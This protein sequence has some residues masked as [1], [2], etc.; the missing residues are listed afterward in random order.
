MIK[1]FPEGSLRKLTA[2]L[3]SC[4]AIGILAISNILAQGRQTPF[5]VDGVV[6]NTQG[7]P[8]MDAVVQI[9]ESTSFTVTDEFGNFSIEIPGTNT[10]IT[11]VADGF[12]MQSVSVYDNTFLEIILRFA[13]EGQR[14]QDRVFVPWGVSDKRS[15]TSSISTIGHSELRKSPVLNL[16]G[17]VSG[18]LPGFTVVQQ[19]GAPGWESAT[20]RVRG[21]RTLEDGGWNSMSKGAVGTPIV[22]VD[23]FERGFTDL[24]PSEIESFSVLKDAAATVLYG[25]RGANGVILVNTRR[26]QANRR[27]IDLEISSGI[28]SPLRLPE[29]LGSYD[30][31][32]LH[33]EARISDGLLPLYSDDDLEKYR[34]GSDPLTHPNN[35][36]YDE[37]IKPYTFQRKS[38]LSMS[39][40]N[41]IVRY[42]VSVVYNNLGSLYDRMNE[43]PEFDTQSRS[44]MYNVRANLDISV[45]RRLS[46]A[47]NLAG[48]I[49][50][51]RYPYGS[52]TE[53]SIFGLL[54]DTPPNAY[55]ISFMGIEPSLNQEILMLGGNVIY[56]TN[57]LGQLS[58]RG[59]S[60]RIYRFFQLGLQF[61][62]DLDFITE[63]L[64][65]SFTFDAD[66]FNYYR[67]SRYKN[68]QVWER[69]VMPD[70]SINY[71]YFNEP[72]SLTTAIGT[73]VEYY[74]GQNLNLTYNRSF[75]LSSIGGLAMWRRY[76]TIIK[77][78]NQPDK[79]I[80]DFAL[81]LNYSF[82]NRYFIE[83][84]A[85]L[86]GSDNFFETNTPRVF[87]P[88]I[89]GAWI[90]SEESFFNNSAAFP[91]V[92]LKA[93]WGLTGNEDYT[94]TDPNGLKYRFPY[95]E[96]WWSSNSR[97][98][99]GTSLAYFN[100]I[101]YEGIL[102]NPDF[103]LEKGRMINFGI[104]TRHLDNRLSF[105][106]EVWFEK[107][108]DIFTRGVGSVPQVIGIRETYLP[109]ENKGIVF[110]K[111]IETLLGWRSSG[112][113]FN[114][115]VNGMVD[116]FTNRI[117]F[118]D[119]PFKEYDYLYETGGM[120]RQ[121]IALIAAGLF[122]DQAD[123]D[124]SPVQMFGP[125]KPGDIKFKDLNGDNIIDAL[126][127][128]TVG[129][130]TFPQLSYAA[131]MGF[132]YLGF[133]FSV[134]F[135]GSS[136][137]SVINRNSVNQA[138]RNNS[139]IASYA[140]GRYTDAA[141]WENATYPRLTTIAND[142]NYRGST[143]WMY[144]LSFVRVKNI[145]LGYNLPDEAV[146]KLGLY[147]VRFF[148]NGYNLMT[149]SRVKDF[150]PEDLTA[151]I[152]KYPMTSIVNL[153][154]NL[155]F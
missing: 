68:Y 101:V 99:Y 2:R 38:A 81:R 76:T 120:V 140:L 27:T 91:Y 92:K 70:N 154:I 7:I 150:D 138:F 129:Y 119:E 139:N 90:I 112:S 10:I 84:S 74:N 102:P 111:G 89:S 64:A 100:P 130:S 24:D 105:T 148:L 32:R 95:R 113:K 53:S 97:T 145:E 39:G 137:R 6:L 85:V 128:K 126:D 14:I 61:K 36:F 124:N 69:Q 43:N 79:K 93:S 23:G 103:T 55:P 78:A 67:V 82:N 58:Y 44:S 13:P 141:S 94:Y 28:V 87:L 40:G 71:V 132:S 48:R 116:Y 155:K 153:G 18:R 33:N 15:I 30:Y 115:W 46:A 37:F 134:L 96:R 117:D 127:M 142:N 104:D 19:S 72:S 62:Y 25:V 57:P 56:T 106:T 65:A 125:V 21:V 80:E 54:A 51:R 133:D 143:Y 5:T 135:Q 108:F 29:F 75:G 149:F 49:E 31:A 63:G 59:N 34:T 11:I 122:R 1:Y 42:F 26:G 17:A 146:R 20:M 131:D 147:G 118:M 60:E 151:G 8:V 35:D 73:D 86:T 4:L 47:L 98:R 12:E 22:I 88:A 83:S 107:R 52:D 109:I 16:A 66:G 9:Q 123:I 136:M 50:D 3:V 152:D 110:S 114:Y 77:Q 121:N 45:T 41:R 144:D